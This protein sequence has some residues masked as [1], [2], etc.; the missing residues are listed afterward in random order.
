ME[1]LQVCVYAY[2]QYGHLFSFLCL[3]SNLA[4]I[5]NRMVVFV[6]F[7]V[8][9]YVSYYIYYIYLSTHFFKVLLGNLGH[10]A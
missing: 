1:D 3:L 5:F 4:I 2:L 8:C 10:Q 6:H 7:Y 9:G